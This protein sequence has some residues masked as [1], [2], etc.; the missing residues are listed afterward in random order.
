MHGGVRWNEDAGSQG[1]R[2]LR[3]WKLEEEIK[4]QWKKRDGCET[5]SF[6]MLATP[7]YT[8]NATGRNAIP[9]GAVTQYRLP[10][11]PS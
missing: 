11:V 6:I 9:R 8:R 10:T 7:A 4:S 5:D 1:N 2:E 3:K